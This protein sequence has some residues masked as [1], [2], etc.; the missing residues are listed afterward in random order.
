MYRHVYFTVIYT[1]ARCIQNIQYEEK[2]TMNL[3][4]LPVA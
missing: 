3:G 1:R 2:L 4:R